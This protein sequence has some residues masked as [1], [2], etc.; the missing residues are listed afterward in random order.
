MTRSTPAGRSALQVDARDDAVAE[1]EGQDVVAVLALFGRRVDLDAVAEIEQAL[2]ARA[3]EDQRVE[4]REQRAGVDAARHPGIAVQVGRV[5]SSPRRDREQLAFLDQFLQ[6]ALHVGG[7][8]A[9][10]VAQIA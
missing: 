2:G 7:R 5:A 4:R 3:L 6:P 8:Q 10:I 9:K 1:Q